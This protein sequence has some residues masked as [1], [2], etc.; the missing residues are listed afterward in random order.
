[1]PDK[2]V[3]LNVA[4]VILYDGRRMLVNRRPDGA[5]F[6]GWWEWPG[7]K[8]QAGEAMVDCARRELME[9]I[10]ISAPDLVEYDRRTVEYPG[11]IVHLVFYVG[12]CPPGASVSSDALE[13]R[14]LE[15]RDVRGLKFLKP[16]LP[17]L[18]RLIDAP[19][20]ESE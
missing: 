8:C 17:V 19:P 20:F 16:N 15:P 9:E 18:E 4:V 12:K 14:W 6:G 7:G 3:E 13:H 5:Y 1:M 2:P 11:R 10:G